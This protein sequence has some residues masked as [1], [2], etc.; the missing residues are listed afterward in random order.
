MIHL[1]TRATRIAG[2][3]ARIAALLALSASAARAEDMRAADAR[4][5]QAELKGDQIV[6]SREGSDR[7]ILVQNASADFRPYIHPLVAPDGRGELTQFRPSHHRHQTGLYWGFMR[8]NR[9]DYFYHPEG[10]YWQRQSSRVVQPRGAEVAWVVVYNLLDQDKQPL[11][12]E[13]QTWKVRELENRYVM[14]LDWLGTAV[15]DVAFDRQDY[16]GLFLRMPFKGQGTAV[17]S[18]GQENGQAEGRRA[19]WVDVAMPIDGR[20]DDAHIAIMDHPKNEHHPLPW[21]VDSQ[22]GVGPCRS[23]LGDWKLVKGQSAHFRHR[24]LVYTGPRDVDGVNKSW[25]EFAETP[26]Q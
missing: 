5:L 24:F 21:R 17:N 22:L 16:G 26:A 6:V 9:R 4:G 8:A 2:L 11:L 23:R 7:P 1:Q 18:A 19:R 13:Q 20:N 10:D 3:A 25:Q 14:D 12:T 15:Q